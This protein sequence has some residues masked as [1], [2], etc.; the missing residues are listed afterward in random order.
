M[1]Y[2]IILDTREVTKSTATHLQWFLGRRCGA[3]V[4][5]L[6]NS[7]K[8]WRGTSWFFWRIWLLWWRWWGCNSRLRQRTKEWNR[9][10]KN[11]C[12]KS[13]RLVVGHILLQVGFRSLLRRQT[14]VRHLMRSIS[15]Q[16]SCLN[17][18]HEA[19]K[20]QMKL[21]ED[22]L[23]F[24]CILYINR[25]CNF[26]Y[27]AKKHMHSFT[28]HVLYRRRRERILKIY[29]SFDLMSFDSAS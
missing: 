14:S 11:L 28:Q 12:L 22:C 27:A 4:T 19:I 24:I 20:N 16:Y 3:P 15:N 6:R 1:I 26:N 9:K 13:S 18:Y 25:K 5:H 7:F 21:V 17:L 29:W 23:H 10:F 8:R 2:H